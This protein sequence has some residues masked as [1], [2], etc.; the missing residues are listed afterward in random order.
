MTNECI[1]FYENHNMTHTHTRSYM[2]Q[3]SLTPHQGHTF[4]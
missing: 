4:V 1:Q 3:A 2:F